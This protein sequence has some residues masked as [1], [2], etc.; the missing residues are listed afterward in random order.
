M[1]A[2]VYRVAGRLEVEE[3]PVPEP[4]PGEM[5]TR[6]DVCGICVTDV[7]KIQKGLIPG[8]RV[9]GHEIA[10]TVA[11]L[12]AGVTRFREGDRV[13]LH[14]HVP[15]GSCFYCDLKAYA[16][17]AFYKHNGTTAGFEPSGGGYAE[18]V[19]ALPSIVD[20]GAIRIPDG[21]AAEEAAL[22]EPVN[23]CLKAIRKAGI[24]QGQ[25]VLVVGQGP[26]GLMLMQL[27]A[28]AGAEVFASDPIPERREMS[29]RLGAHAILDPKADVAAEVRALTGGRGADCVILAVFGATAFRQAVDS[30]RPGGK[31]MVFA[32]T[33]RGETVEVDLG[34]LCT[35]EKEILTSYSSS[36]D[37]QDLAAELVFKR[38]IRVGELITH[39]LP[40]ARAAEAVELA[41][42]ARPGVLKIVLEMGR[43][44]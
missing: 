6:V 33:A 1:K 34:E 29:R 10:G 35:S 17:C 24:T 44:E 42:Q 27:A 5:L 8:P 31:V 15:C 26:I 25:T 37:L 13:V 4:G 9:F 16:Q 11:R 36:F 39:R 23:T 3:L 21:V 22:V 30:T 40:L 19:K 12:G 2:A 14:H 38:E 7:K 18:Y 41:S 43:P 20:R 28:W 32:A